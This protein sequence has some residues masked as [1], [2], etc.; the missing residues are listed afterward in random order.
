MSHPFRNE[1]IYFLPDPSSSNG[2]IL[3]EERSLICDMHVY[4][5]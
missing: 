1:V 3:K 5:D 4:L 2:K